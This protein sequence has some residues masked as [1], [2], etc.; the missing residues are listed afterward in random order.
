M[1]YRFIAPLFNLKLETV[2]NRGIELFPGARITNGSEERTKILNTQ[3]MKS[4]AGVHSLREFN[5]ATYLYIDGVFDSIKTEDEMD[6]I[7]VKYTFYYLRLAQGFI[8]DLW[9]VKDNNIYVRDGFLLAYHNK[10]ED[11]LTYKASLSE[12]YYHSTCEDKESNFTRSEIQ[13]VARDF[14][15]FPIDEY[16]EKHFGGKNPDSDH[17]F[18][19]KGSNRLDRAF[20]FTLMARTSSIL[21]MKIVG[22]CNALE[23]L[24][25]I[26][27]SEVNHK[28]AERVALMLGTTGESKKELFKLIKKA[29]DYRSLVVH[30]Q[31]LKGEELQLVDISQKLDDILRQLLNGKHDV[32]SKKDTEMVET[33]TNLLFN[34]H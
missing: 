31:H 26:G 24:F 32:F 15:P 14:T 20:Y 8:Y 21:P 34:I 9:K 11:G 22:Y 29:Y 6:E 33:F 28:I 1:K 13:L 18:K 10:F 3:L 25:T 4:T 23:C 27:T 12:I 5:D 2:L 7:G 19:N 17:L 16:D 30:G